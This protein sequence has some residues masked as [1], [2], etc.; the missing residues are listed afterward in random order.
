[1]LNAGKR[2]AILVGIGAMQMNGINEL[3][4][5]ARYWRDWEDPRLIVMV[6]NNRDLNMVTWEMRAMEG[7]PA[8]KASQELPD[9]PSAR[10]AESIGLKGIRVDDPG[11]V[12]SAWDEALAATCPV[13]YEAIVDPDV[14]P[15]PPHISFDQAKDYM[16]AMVKGDAHALG[17]IKHALQH[18]AVSFS[19]FWPRTSFPSPSGVRGDWLLPGI[20]FVRLSKFSQDLTITTAVS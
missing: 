11:R 20:F 13:V 10:Y 2:V 8:F 16:S 6:L 5:I 1:M 7:T 18:M 12:A 4:T 15:L 3:L 14:P 19:R 17:V 9:F